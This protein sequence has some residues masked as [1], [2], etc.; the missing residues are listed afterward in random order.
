MNRNQIH[1][2]LLSAFV[3]AAALSAPRPAAAQDAKQ[4]YAA[5]ARSNNI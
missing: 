2:I 4:P 3:L 1:G 5:M